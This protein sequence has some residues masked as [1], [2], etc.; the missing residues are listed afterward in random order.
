VDLNPDDWTLVLADPATNYQL[1]D[2]AAAIT[3]PEHE[4]RA[5]PVLVLEA[6]HIETH[7]HMRLTVRVPTRYVQP[8]ALQ[9]AAMAQDLDDQQRRGR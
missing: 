6:E 8:L 2:Y 1:H 7:V 9:F 4:D 5:Q 3:D